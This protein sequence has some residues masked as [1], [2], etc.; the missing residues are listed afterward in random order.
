MKTPGNTERIIQSCSSNGESFDREKFI[1]AIKE[2]TQDEFNT[3]CREVSLLNH[4]YASSISVP[5]C[6]YGDFVEE[7]AKMFFKH[8]I[9]DMD[10]R[11]FQI[12]K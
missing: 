8:A 12:Q 2:M 5:A 7:N 6:D 10:K 3:F 1:G 9:I 11:G 4:H